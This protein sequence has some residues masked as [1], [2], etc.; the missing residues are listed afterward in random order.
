MTGVL[1]VPTGTGPSQVALEM[2]GIS[3]R[4]PGVQALAGV[5]LR[6]LRGEIHAVVGENG[7][8]KST[9]MKILAGAY[10]A[11]AGTIQLDGRAVTF[12]SPHEA[13]AMGIGMVYQELNLV[14]DLSVA[15]NIFLGRQPVRRFG[16]VERGRLRTAAR[17]LLD[18]L[19]APLDPDAL[20]RDLSVGQRQMVE[21]AKAYSMDPGILV[22]DEPTS[23]LTEHETSILFG[24]LRRLRG[25]GIAIIFISHRLREVME[26]SDRVTVLRDGRLVG[27]RPIT[28]LDP[29]EIVRMMVGRE[30]TDLFPKRTVPIGEVVFEVRGY[31]R[32]GVFQ[33]V[34]FQVRSGE[35]LGLAG[36]VG[37]GR[38]EVARAIFGLDAHDSGELLLDGRPV[39]IRGPRDAVK[40]RV[41][42]VPEDRKQDGLVLGLTVRDNTVMSILSELARM[43]VIT[44]QL[45][46]PTVL[47]MIER[48]RLRPPDP[49]RTVA[50]LSGGNQQKVVMG[51]WT[52]ATPRV[53]FLDEPTR[54]VDVGA[55]A[56]I[57]GLMGELAAQGVAIVMISSELVEVLSASDRILVLH[58]GRVTGELSRD[59]ATEERIML[60]ATGQGVLA[61]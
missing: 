30:V 37:A 12:G 57:H 9:L 46:T 54:G 29:A 4:F 39:R 22:L 60:A 50:T 19:G 34:S 11:D 47:S 51:R 13:Q 17:A 20:I 36:L 31:S 24:T 15:E 23:A 28:E 1:D 61:A 26:I 7:A 38:T 43:G 58:Q 48:F 5:D 32:A 45:E 44:R 59:E 10:H 33:D 35:I 18:T 8:G 25:R 3:K 14:P 52:A 21:V 49:D 56:E 27:S 16:W 53:L 40:A 42:Y 6:V 55:K 41:G 2:T